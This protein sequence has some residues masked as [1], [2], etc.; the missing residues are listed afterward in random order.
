MVAASSTQPFSHTTTLFAFSMLPALVSQAT[1]V[2]N[3]APGIL[4]CKTFTVTH[5]S[6]LNKVN[7]VQ[8]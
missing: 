4:L 8:T 6:V 7:N 3:F 5:K 2:L 1:Q